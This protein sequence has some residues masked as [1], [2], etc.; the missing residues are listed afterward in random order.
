METQT[1]HHSSCEF[2]RCFSQRAG[3]GGFKVER[4]RRWLSA[5]PEEGRP[6]QEPEAGTLTWPT[7]PPAQRETNACCHRP[8][9]LWDLSQRPRRLTHPGQHKAVVT[10]LWGPAPT[11]WRP[12]RL[13]WWQEQRCT[14]AGDS[15]H[16]GQRETMG[17][18]AEPGSELGGRVPG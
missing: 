3:G 6:P 14:R 18:E 2:K 16:R 13:S 1:F 9:R 15:L 12:R 11:P 5:S 7:P 10:W 4:L 17:T 8:P